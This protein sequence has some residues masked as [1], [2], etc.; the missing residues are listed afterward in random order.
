MANYIE[1]YSLKNTKNFTTITSRNIKSNI[2][3][4]GD[5]K[6]ITY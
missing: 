3:L 5:D 4:Y 6:K 1:E 2:L